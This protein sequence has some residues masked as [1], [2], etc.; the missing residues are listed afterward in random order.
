MPDAKFP[1]IRARSLTGQQ[2]QLPGDLEGV[3]NVTVIAFRMW[4]QELVDEWFRFLEPLVAAAPD[5]RAYELPVLSN[6]YWLARPMIDGGMS[7]G[8]PSL[9]VRQRTLTIYTDVGRFTRALAIGST[10]TITT[11]L[12]DRPGKILWR[13]MGRFDQAQAAGLE[14]QITLGPG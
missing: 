7:A 3:L 1:Q 9:A 5:V 11:L 14:R 6:T 2:Y 4:H 13:G 8:I 10:G 12:L